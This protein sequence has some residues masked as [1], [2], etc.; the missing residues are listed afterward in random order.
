MFMTITLLVFL[1]IR[2]SGELWYPPI[3]PLSPYRVNGDSCGLFNMSTTFISSE[4]GLIDVALESESMDKDCKQTIDYFIID[5]IEHIRNKRK[6][7][8]DEPTITY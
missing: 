2:K 5:T 6:K 7:R 3:Y 1:V 4:K 8:E